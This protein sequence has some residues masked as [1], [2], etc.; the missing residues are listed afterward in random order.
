M[1]SE[2]SRVGQSQTDIMPP[3]FPPPE[4]IKITKIWAGGIP[5]RTSKEK[6]KDAFIKGF[7]IPAEE[8]RDITV[9]IKLGYGF[10][11]VPDTLMCKIDDELQNASV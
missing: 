8:S 7:S 5:P 4:E 11:N 10:I 9:I 3:E 2:D 6:L 1:S